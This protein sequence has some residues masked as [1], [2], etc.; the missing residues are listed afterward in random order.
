M[1][2]GT[3]EAAELASVRSSWIAQW[4]AVVI[5]AGLGATVIWIGLLLWLA[6]A[7]VEWLIS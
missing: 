7:V 6:W 4:P 1:Q 3:E 2:P 5:F